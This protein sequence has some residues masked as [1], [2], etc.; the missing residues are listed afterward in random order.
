M[1]TNLIPL[2]GGHRPD[3]SVGDSYRHDAIQLEPNTGVHGLFGL[4]LLEKARLH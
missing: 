2:V 3:L 1:P 4:D